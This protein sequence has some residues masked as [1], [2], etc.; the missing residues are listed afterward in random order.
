MFYSLLETIFIFY[1]LYNLSF[2]I[3]YFE[4]INI[5]PKFQFQVLTRDIRCIFSWD[6]LSP[7][8]FVTVIADFYCPEPQMLIRSNMK[9]FHVR[10]GPDE[11]RVGEKSRFTLENPSK[12]RF[13]A[14]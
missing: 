9:N 2:E 8:H 3:I 13:S 12:S 1:F 6:H 14:S 4:E 11:V 10:E 7:L 5:I